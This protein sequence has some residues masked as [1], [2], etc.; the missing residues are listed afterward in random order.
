MSWEQ[1]KE[2]IARL[3]DPPTESTEEAPQPANQ[4]SV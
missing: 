1:M 3:P 4:P 2:L